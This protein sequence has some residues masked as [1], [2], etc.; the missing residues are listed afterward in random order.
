M[1]CANRRPHKAPGES[2]STTH[3]TIEWS[4]AK[5]VLVSVPGQRITRG[6]GRRDAMCVSGVLVHC[7]GR[8]GAAVSV[9]AA[10]IPCGDGVSAE[11]ALESGK[12]VHHLDRVMSH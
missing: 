10:E 2:R 3:L 6:Y 8:L 12:P 7:P 4:L 11:W 5:C 9:L 1:P